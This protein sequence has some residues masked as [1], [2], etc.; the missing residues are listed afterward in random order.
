MK[1]P[2]NFGFLDFSTLEKRRHFCERE[3][4]LNRRLCPGVHLGVLPI[5]LRNGRLSFAPGGKIVEYAVEMRRLPERWFLLRLLARGEVSE[6]DVDAI[7]ATLAPFY[8]AQKP[9]P[10]IEQWGRVAK[11]RISTDENFG[12]PET[13]SARQSHVRRSRP[14]GI[15]RRHFI[16]TTPR[17]SQ[18]E[19]ARDASA[20]A[21]AICILTTS[22]SVPGG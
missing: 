8:E 6:R 2:V 17:C 20:I 1:K 18:R 22:I 13:S 16:G 11:L 19:F 5:S 15:T 12:K 21:T 3:V 14:F 9:T 4:A 7:V 10:E